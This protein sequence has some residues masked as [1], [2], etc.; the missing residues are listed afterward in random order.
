MRRVA[1]RLDHDPRQVDALRPSAFG[2]QRAA[3]RVHAR[4][5]VGEKVRM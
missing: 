3:N 2:R 1:R 5:Y 4:Q